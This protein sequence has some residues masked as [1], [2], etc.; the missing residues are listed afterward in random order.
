MVEEV[1]RRAQERSFAEETEK[2]RR[3]LRQKARVGIYR[4]P[5]LG[6]DRKKVVLSSIVATTP[7]AGARHAGAHTNP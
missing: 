5:V 6:T 3:D 4:I 2:W 1:R 7:S